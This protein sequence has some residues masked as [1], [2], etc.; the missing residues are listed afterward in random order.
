MS[1][2]FDLEN[3]KK[4]LS[5]TELEEKPPKYV[6]VCEELQACLGLPGLP[7]GD[8]SEIHGDSDTGKTTIMMHAAT[9]A[10]AQGVFPV[11]IIV[12]KKHRQERLKLMGF[13]PNKAIV[14]LT[15]KSVEDIFEFSDKI[16]AA[17]NKG[18]LPYDTMI[19]ID[20]LGNVNCRAARLEN[21]DGTTTVKNV[22]QQNAK[23]ITEH[24]M[25]MSDKL[26]D[27]RYVNSP[28]YIGMTVLNQVY[29]KPAS[30]PGGHP[31]KQP[32]GG[33][34]LKYTSSIQL[35]TKKVKDLVAKVDGNSLSFGMISKVSVTKNHIN[36]IK[37]TGTYVITNDSI[38]ANDEGAIKDYKEKNRDKWGSA[39]IIA[40]D[41]EED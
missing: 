10:Q 41:S 4:T 15:C 12:E 8:I 40:T 20:S 26:G 28:H 5:F 31:T 25:I 36:G 6:T 22:H 35:E 29:D 2:N 17:V 21:K 30:F 3:F 23:A 33:K 18:K 34:K 38:F 13:D 39:E 1:K 7:L 11:L 9:Q 19:F 14:N 37:N 32:R 16:I 27:S 24:L